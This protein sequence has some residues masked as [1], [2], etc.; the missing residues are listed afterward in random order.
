MIQSEEPVLLPKQC[1]NDEVLNNLL[2]RT[3]VVQMVS[4]KF[5]FSLISSAVTS[6][7]KPVLLS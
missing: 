1:R 7:C 3:L 2:I 4:M 6:S 5:L